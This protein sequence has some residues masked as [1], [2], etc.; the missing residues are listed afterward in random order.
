M[1]CRG[2]IMTSE[3]TPM[4]ADMPMAAGLVTRRARGAGRVS[5]T[6]IGMLVLGLKLYEFGQQTDWEFWRDLVS[7]SFASVHWDQWVRIGIIFI[8][9]LTAA[10]VVSIAVTYVVV[11]HSINNT[12]NNTNTL[13]NVTN[14]NGQDLG[15][16]IATIGGQL[17]EVRE[18]ISSFEKH[19]VRTEESE[20]QRMKEFL[21][22]A[23]SEK[24]KQKEAQLEAD[25]RRFD[26]IAESLRKV[27]E[28]LNR[29]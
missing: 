12:T 24:V 26:D 19:L 17:A 1:I 8:E 23:E 20:R 21:G 13:T 27:I 11:N 9:A 2:V 7:G 14:Y 3:A 29:P 15:Q 25:K 10:A 22:F 28:V 5:F 4:R 16:V 6:L 18:R